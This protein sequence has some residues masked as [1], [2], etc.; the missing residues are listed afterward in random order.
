M[1]AEIRNYIYETILDEEVDVDLVTPLYSTSVISSMG[2]LKLISFLERKYDISIPMNNVKIE[3]FDNV[4]MISAF[5]ED[6]RL[7]TVN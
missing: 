4:N 6:L 2:H 7:A 5:V 3:N 1:K